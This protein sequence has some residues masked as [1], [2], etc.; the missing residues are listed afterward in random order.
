MSP[1]GGVVGVGA[2][3]LEEEEEE[4]PEVLS[5]YL[6]GHLP[7]LLLAGNCCEVLPCSLL[8]GVWYGRLPLTLRFF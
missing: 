7:F 1:G 5:W 8:T 4:E 6:V 2:K 3:H